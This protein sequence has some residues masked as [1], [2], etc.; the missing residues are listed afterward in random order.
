MKYGTL[1]F[2][3]VMCFFSGSAFCMQTPQPATQEFP[4]LPM[5]KRS[6]ITSEEQPQSGSLLLLK[7]TRNVRS[8]RSF[9]TMKID[10][11]SIVKIEADRSCLNEP[12]NDG[13]HVFEEEDKAAATRDGQLLDIHTTITGEQIPS[14]TTLVGHLWTITESKRRNR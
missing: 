4:V 1:L 3:V 5:P 8:K 12:R 10:G 14:I 13:R 2:Y 9:I 7:P 6:K 11:K